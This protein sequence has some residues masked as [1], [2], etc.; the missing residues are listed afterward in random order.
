M[1]KNFP[2][3][4]RTLDKYFDNPQTFEECIICKCF[5]CCGYNPNLCHSLTNDDYRESS[6]YVRECD[7]DT[8]TLHKIITGNLVNEMTKR[9]RN[10]SEE[11][12]NAR[13]ERMKQLNEERK[14]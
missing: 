11:E 13:R 1:I 9:R 4:K 14:K 8:C 2:Q 7:I 3:T 12:R 5:D 6:Q 10:V